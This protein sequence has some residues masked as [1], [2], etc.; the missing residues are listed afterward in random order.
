VALTPSAQVLA[1]LRQG[2]SF[3]DFALQQS[4]RHAEYFRGQVLPAE[5]QQ[6][7]EQAARD[8]LAAQAELEAQP[9]GDFDAFVSAYQASILALA[10]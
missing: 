10:V 5:Q 2:Q 6:A 8:S 7:F 4:L 3:T 9:E 1:I